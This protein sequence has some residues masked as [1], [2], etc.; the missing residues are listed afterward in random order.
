M[1][2]AS[3]LYRDS[4]DGSIGLVGLQDGRTFSCGVTTTPLYWS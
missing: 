1:T 2:N 3:W 4:I